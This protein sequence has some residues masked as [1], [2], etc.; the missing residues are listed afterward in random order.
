[1]TVR[2]GFKTSPQGVDWSVLDATWA[3][4]ADEPV[5]DS[6]WL[7]DHLTDPAL[8]RGGASFEA[9]TTLAGLAHHLRGRWI[10]HVVLSNTFRH[11]ALLAKAATTLDHLSGGRF[12]LGLGAGWHE[13]E[14]LDFGIPLPPLGERI[15][16]LESAVRVV[17]A[18]QSPAAS[19]AAGVDL[20]DPYYPLRGA[21]DLPS[22]VEPGGI[23]IWLGGQG[24]RGLELAARLAD[25][26][27]VPSLPFVDV[28]TFG[29]RRA[30][31]RRRLDDVGRGDVPFRFAAQVPTGDDAA[32]LTEARSL[33]RGY[34]AAGA[35]DLI[36]GMPARLGPDGL[37]RLAAEVARPLHDA[38]G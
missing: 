19:G 28:E 17:R 16:R 23:P 31:L 1:V 24:P 20:D 34:A 3:V 21:V 5:F 2:I 37:R 32:S 35:T 9:V 29:A 26:W 13:H 12:V 18:L 4:A 36:I 22:P 25:G 15:S 7:N 30:A 10:G 14:H 8:D 27:V 33:G 11:P 38:L 6:G